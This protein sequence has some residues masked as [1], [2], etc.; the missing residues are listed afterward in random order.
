[1]GENRFKRGLENIKASEEKENIVENT[2]YNTKEDI[3]DNISDKEGKKILDKIME[4][5]K[6]TRG[7]NYSLYLSPE[8]GEYLINLSKRTNKSKSALVDEILKEVFFEK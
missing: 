8:V 4:K 6:K 5:D 7:N 2:I 1:M 3:I